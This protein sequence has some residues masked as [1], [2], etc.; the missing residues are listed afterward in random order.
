[1]SVSVA[2]SSSNFS[3][4]NSD[5]SNQFNLEVSEKT[6]NWDNIPLAKTYSDDEIEGVEGIDYILS[7]DVIEFV[8]DEVS[9]K[10]INTQSHSNVSAKQVNSTQNDYED[11]Q[12]I[13][14]EDLSKFKLAT[15]YSEV[16]DTGSGDGYILI[17]EDGVETFI[18]YET[19]SSAPSSIINADTKIEKED[20]PFFKNVKSTFSIKGDS[21]H[22]GELKTSVKA[23]IGKDTSISLNYKLEDDNLKNPNNETHTLS[24]N[25]NTKVTDKF[26]LNNEI[27][28]EY[29]SETDGS[30]PYIKIGGK[31]AGDS[32]ATT[33]NVKFKES[34]DPV[35]TIGAAWDSKDGLKASAKGDTD[36]EV[37]I[38]ASSRVKVGDNTSVTFGT[39]WEDDDHRSSN[40]EEWTGSIKGKYEF[41]PNWS[42]QSELGLV[43]NTEIDQTNDFANSSITYKNSGHSS[44]LKFERDEQNEHKTSLQYGYKF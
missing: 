18:E 8:E 36:G 39:K 4:S 25:A 35:M 2:G 19:K 16:P 24:A 38:K 34:S 43:H 44:T 15:T 14:A 41:N 20:T 27:G 13:K 21:N 3:T 10:V 6:R 33:A 26:S 32:V 29:S 37:T 42:I 17:D 23:K 1:M 11:G 28:T 7:D 40:N 9:D 12:V 5:N 22:E 31:W 30:T